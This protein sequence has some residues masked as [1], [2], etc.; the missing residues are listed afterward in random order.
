MIAAFT[1]ERLITA[2]AETTPPAGPRIGYFMTIATLLLVLCLV[3]VL[4]GIYF[5]FTKSDKPQI[6]FSIAMIAIVLLIL[7]DLVGLHR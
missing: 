7:M 6:G 2:G 3:L 4:A 1:A 5:I